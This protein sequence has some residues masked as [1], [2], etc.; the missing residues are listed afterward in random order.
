MS[1]TRRLFLRHTAAAGAAGATIAAPAVADAAEPMTPDE[2]ISAAIEEIKIAFWEKWPDCPL[3]IV[4][5][6]NGSNG[7]LIILSHV[8]KDRSGEVHYE[9]NGTARATGGQRNG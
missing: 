9:R 6:D 5:T 8:G 3:R 4:D 7:G 1:I 2:R